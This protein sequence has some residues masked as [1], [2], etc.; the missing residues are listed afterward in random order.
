MLVYF[1]GQTPPLNVT[2]E[3][4][5]PLFFDATQPSVQSYYRQNSYG[6]MNVEGEVR[7]WL[8]VP[9]APT[10]EI[11]ELIETSLFILDRRDSG[12]QFSDYQHFL[13][14]APYPQIGCAAGM[15]MVG[16][17][18]FAT[19]D[20]PVTA[21]GSVVR[22]DHIDLYTLIHEFGHGLGLHH[23][24]LLNCDLG[25]TNAAVCPAWEYGD[26]FDVMGGAFETMGGELNAP[27]REMMGWIDGQA[28]RTVTS[29]GMYIIAPIASTGPGTKAL[30]IWR[31]DGTYLYI[32]YRQAI[33]FDQH[34]DDAHAYLGALLHL[35]GPDGKTFLVDPTPPAY[36]RMN[37]LEVGQTFFDVASGTRVETI[38]QTPNALQVRITIPHKV[39]QMPVRPRPIDG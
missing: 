7:D 11:K 13:V 14:I 22:A 16:P 9:I 26:H 4:V 32:E 5:A 12:V 20:G 39:Q 23:A 19:P 21:S 8:L 34:L 2:D 31:G 33:G 37:S 30:K 17:R 35:S 1:S 29:N 38:A 6:R 24:G 3:T 27:H 18:T 28:M 36:V 15:S 25:V 10:C